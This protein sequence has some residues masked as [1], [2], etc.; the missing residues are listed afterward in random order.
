M[1][2]IAILMSAFRPHVCYDHP[3]GGR[4]I[5]S[6]PSILCDYTGKQ[7]PAMSATRGPKSSTPPPAKKMP[8][9]KGHKNRNT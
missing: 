2:F 8:E 7:L 3:G 1:F 9:T 4:S 6:E 5:I